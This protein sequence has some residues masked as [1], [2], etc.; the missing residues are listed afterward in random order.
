MRT[1][2]GG[3]RRFTNVV[4][5]ADVGKKPKMRIPSFSAIK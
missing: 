1:P 2:V 3:Q 4:K 5:F